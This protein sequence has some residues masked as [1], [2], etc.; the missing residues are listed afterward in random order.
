MRLSDEEW[1]TALLEMGLDLEEFYGLFESC[2]IEEL[3]ERV[4]SFQE[5]A[6]KGYRSAA[7]ELHPDRNNGDSESEAKFKL[8]S[9][10]YRAITAMTVKKKKKAPKRK[11]K[12]GTL[13][14]RLKVKDG[15]QTTKKRS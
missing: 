9:N 3:K 2:G 11:T 13:T 4:L 8:V 1:I 7:L 15:I 10:A 14:I 5:K 6:K 12:K